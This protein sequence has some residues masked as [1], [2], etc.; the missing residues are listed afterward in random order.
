MVTAAA[1]SDSS[2]FL[3]HP[4]P[5]CLWHP[6]PIP[7]K[8]VFWWVTAQSDPSPILV[9][10]LSKIPQRRVVSVVDHQFYVIRCDFLVAIKIIAG[11]QSF[12]RLFIIVIR[13][14]PVFSCNYGGEKDLH[15]GLFFMVFDGRGM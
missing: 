13:E 6:I 1:F 8:F 12:L 4:R 7:D 15:F 2:L 5:H 9:R 3:F 10:S 11:F 14:F